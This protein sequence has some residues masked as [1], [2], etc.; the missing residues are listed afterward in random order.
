[1]VEAKNEDKCYV[2]AYCAHA[3]LTNK[4][5]EYRCPFGGSDFCFKKL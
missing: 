3:I 5:G 1:M 4:I 2:G